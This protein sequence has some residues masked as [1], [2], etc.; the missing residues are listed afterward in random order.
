MNLPV[1]SKSLIKSVYSKATVIKLQIELKLRE[2]FRH[3]S[4]GWCYTMH[5]SHLFPTTEASTLRSINSASASSCFLDT[6]SANSAG[7]SK[8]IQNVLHV[9]VVSSA[10][11]VAPSFSQTSTSTLSLYLWRRCRNARW[12]LQMNF[13]PVS[14]FR[15]RR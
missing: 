8:Q 2:Q 9:S 12:S 5:P 6:N 7:N 15:R 11:L 3:P 1:D 14:T 4:R 10:F 13:P